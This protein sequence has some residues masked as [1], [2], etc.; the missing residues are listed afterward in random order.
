M[1]KALT[2]FSLLLV[3]FIGFQ[4]QAARYNMDQ[5]N[6]DQIIVK[7][8]QIESV[9]V[10]NLPDLKAT[11]DNQVLTEGKDPV[12][13]LILCT[14]LS[15]VGAHRY[16]L[17]T[18][19]INGLWYL[20]TWWIPIVHVIDWVMLLLVVIDKKDLSPYIDNPKFIMWKDQL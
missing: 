1:K 16:Y 14:V 17:G 18:N 13:A 4:A 9:S 20:L 19:P 7:A 10:F 11:P 3:M 5:A 6:L 8:H 12:I 2:L 15:W